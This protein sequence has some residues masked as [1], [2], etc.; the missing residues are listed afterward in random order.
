MIYARSCAILFTGAVIAVC[1]LLLYSKSDGVDGLGFSVAFILWPLFFTLVY[2]FVSKRIGSLITL[3]V[4]SLCYAFYFVSAFL[5]FVT[6]TDPQAGLPLWFSA[7]PSLFFMVPFWIIVSYQ[8]EQV[9]RAEIAEMEKQDKDL[10]PLK[11]FFTV[12]LHQEKDD[13]VKSHH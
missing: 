9:S 4:A 12:Q 11:S 8:E 13:D 5:Q 7:I 2:E 6:D 1:S 10:P 3:T